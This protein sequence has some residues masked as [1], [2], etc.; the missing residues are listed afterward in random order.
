MFLPLVVICHDV[1][2]I[3]LVICLEGIGLAWM[4]EGQH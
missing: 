3:V 4:H 1:A 2:M